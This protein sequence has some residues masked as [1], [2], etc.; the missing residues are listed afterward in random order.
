MRRPDARPGDGEFDASQQAR[1]SE[2]VA[3]TG[4]QNSKDSHIVSVADFGVDPRPYSGPV[5]SVERTGPAHRKPS[6]PDG[7]SDEWRDTLIWFGIPVVIMLILRFLVFGFYSIPSGSMM[8]TIEIGDHVVT[9]QLTTRFT[10]LTRG[11]IIVFR[12]PAHWLAN[13]GDASGQGDLIKRLI[14]LPGD[15][16]ECKG[17]GQPVTING[18]AINETSYIR[19]GV[20]PSNFAFKVTV[21][22]GHVF[23]LGDNRANSA[24]SR[25]HQD[26]GDQ[27]LVPINDIRGI[28]LVTY[29]P[30]NRIGRLDNHADVFRNV[31][32]RGATAQSAAAPRRS[33]A[34]LG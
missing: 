6:R 10:S 5:T 24:D 21:S 2:T 4:D 34:T 9:T 7:E 19:P 27:G 3:L 31:P 12:D 26:D 28:G 25:Y 1:D 14:G 18:V 11:D 29:W 13:E 33:A 30:L 8:D 16:V 15:V 22:A 23:V 32:D 17:N 20:S